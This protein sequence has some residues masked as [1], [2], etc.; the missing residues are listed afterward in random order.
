MP[1]IRTCSLDLL[2]LGGASK[3]TVFVVQPHKGSLGSDILWLYIYIQRENESTKYVYIYIYIHGLGFR[4][5]INKIKAR[6]LE[7]NMCIYIYIHGLGF[8]AIINKLKARN[9]EL[10]GDRGPSTELGTQWC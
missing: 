6:N 9:L 2:L 8:R 7:R 5:I 10:G 3:D 1:R 4:A